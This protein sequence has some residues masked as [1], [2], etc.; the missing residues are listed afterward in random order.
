MRGDH[1]VGQ[2]SL[3][4]TSAGTTAANGVSRKAFGCRSPDVFSEL[5]VNRDGTLLEGVFDMVEI[6]RRDAERSTKPGPL[7]TSNSCGTN[8]DYLGDDG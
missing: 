6:E 1:E 3:G 2:Q 5:E 8:P 4:R 7:I